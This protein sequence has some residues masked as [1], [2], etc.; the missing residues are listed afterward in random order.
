MSNF[1]DVTFGEHLF[2][3]IDENLYLQ[4]IYHSILVNYSKRLFQ[5]DEIEEMP[6]NIGHALTFADVLSKSCGTNLSDIHKTRAQ[7]IVAL[8]YDMY[9]HDEQIKY[10]LGSVLANTGHFL[11]MRRLTPEYASASFLDEILMHFNM[12]Y[13]SV[14]SEDDSHFFPAQKEIYDRLSKSCFS[15]SAPTSMGKSFMMRVFIKQ[16]IM[17]GAKK[18]FALLIPTKALINEVTSELIESLTTLLKET[19][20]RIVTSSGSMAL[21]TKHNYIFVLTPERML[22]IL[23]DDPK[24]K[25]DYLFV[26]EAHK[27][28]SGDKRSAFYY[29]VINQLEER[30]S[31]THIVFASPNIP[32]PNVYLDTLTNEKRLDDNSIVACRY[33]PVSQLKYIVDLWERN[34]R[35]FDSYTKKFILLHQMKRQYS[36]SEI[37]ARIGDKRH[38]IV[39]CKS[40]NDAIQ[41]ARDY[42]K[43]QAIMGDKKLQAFAEAIRTD[44]HREYY[45][46]ELVERGV[47]YHI[48]YLPANIRMQLEDYYRDGLIK[49]MFCTST[50]LEGVNLPAENLFI[51]SYKKGLSTF[52]EVDFKNLV[53]RVGRA[54]YN[55]YGNVFI[56]RLQ[57][58]E[59]EEDL[60]KYE[61]LL[62]D[63]VPPQKLSIEIE[64]NSNQ[65]RLIIDTLISGN[66]EIH[67]SNKQQSEDNYELMRKTM[68]ILVGD[69]VHNRNSRIRREFA[70]YLTNEI[71]RQIREQFSADERKPSDDINVSFDQMQ[72]VAKLISEGVSYPKILDTKRGADYSETLEFLNKLAVAFKWRIYESRTLGAGEG[73][74]YTK[75]TWYAVLLLQWIQGH[76]L[77]NIINQ[78]IKDYDDK[79]RK[80]RVD[81]KEW[82]IFDGSQKHKNIIIADT[83][84]A[85]EDVILFRLSNYFLKFSEEYNRQHPDEPLKHDWFEFVEYGTTNPLRI[86]LQRSGFKR[87]STEYIRRNADKYV[88]GT[89]D[90]PKLLKKALLDCPNELVKRD[91]EEIQY[92]VPELFIEEGED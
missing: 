84:E 50:L 48:G 61:C 2:S 27:I 67:K 32:N 90:N 7:E 20:Y 1:R 4:K 66:I 33:A 55:L 35:I 63:E 71:E 59:R 88:R 34:I 83:L 15:Y 53:G 45:L 57:K 69:I 16:Q 36:L 87:E 40:K 82:E 89:P 65:K 81:F 72:G 62:K 46:A 68:L 38:N 47:A 70:P 3:R 24:I 49:T 56:V 11:G 85:I 44:V 6:I 19:D 10:Y 8:L 77:S 78:S 92:N 28:S 80:V 42:A 26:D 74:N 30:H 58:Q 51:T 41:F 39:Y 5:L 21:E 12:N 75:L 22:Y 25:I 79:K 91:T 13:L 29:K 73:Q 9:P 54:K 76:G 18:N 86:I 31:D 43:T 52:S 14:P 64:L 17:N 37:I 60:Q 23:I